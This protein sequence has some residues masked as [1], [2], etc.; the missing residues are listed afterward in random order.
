MNIRPYRDA[1]LDE[2]L[3]AWEASSRLAHPFLDDDFIAGERRNIA[4]LYLPNTESWVCEHDGR[5]VG[6]IAL[7]ALEAGAEIGG[8]F[9]DPAFHGRGFGRAL[10]DHVRP[11]RETL[12]VEV[13][14][15]NAIGRAFYDRYGFAPMGRSVHE[16][17]GQ[18]VLRLV[19]P[20]PGAAA[21]GA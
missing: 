2:L 11:S 12:E 13:F 5:V 18:A 14:E 3:T 8:L 15:A 17:T 21:P 9:V 20:G 19:L 1:D 16:A 6:F 10:V 7:I 4:E